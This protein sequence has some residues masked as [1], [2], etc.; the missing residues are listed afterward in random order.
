MDKEEK[1]LC[2]YCN[3]NFLKHSNGQWAYTCVK[4]VSKRQA[5]IRRQKY[6]PV[7][8]LKKE[9][10]ICKKEF[11]TNNKKQKFCQDPCTYRTRNEAEMWMNKKENLTPRN[12]EAVAYSF[13]RKKYGPGKQF[14]VCRG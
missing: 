9:C 1:I 13:F 6:V 14:K 2:T 10:E 7:K 5:E 11:E 4:C 8:M 12:N 3:E